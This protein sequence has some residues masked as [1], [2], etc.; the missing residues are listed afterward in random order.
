MWRQ[1]TQQPFSEEVLTHWSA[2]I[3]C[4]YLEYFI[5][6][7]QKGFPSLRKYLTS[8]A[9]HE[10]NRV[11]GNSSRVE[12]C[13]K[14]RAVEQGTQACVQGRT[15]PWLSS[16]SQKHGARPPKHN[17][18]AGCCH[19]TRIYIDLEASHMVPWACS[20]LPVS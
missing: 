10:S 2:G 12:L 9:K 19:G 16:G 18:Y 8:N 13:P 14:A 11:K 15:K 7:K 6:A 17:V 1:H 3:G 4:F 5:P 20:C